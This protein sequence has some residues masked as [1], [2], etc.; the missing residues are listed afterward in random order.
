[1]LSIWK[2]AVYYTGDGTSSLNVER[3]DAREEAPW[4]PTG[5]NRQRLLDDDGRT[6]TAAHTSKHTQTQ[7]GRERS[8]PLDFASS[9]RLKSTK[10]KGKES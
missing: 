1:M 2:P 5:T 8:Q 10:G 9:E 3:R 6:R 7:T 4:K